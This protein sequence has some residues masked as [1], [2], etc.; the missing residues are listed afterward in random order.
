M[1]LPQLVLAFA[2]TFGANGFLIERQLGAAEA[3]PA[4]RLIEVAED[5]RVVFHARN[6]WAMA[7][8]LPAMEDRS[9]AAIASGGP[10]RQVVAPSSRLYLYA[11]YYLA[12]GG[13][14]P[15]S[16]MPVDVA[17]YYFHALLGAALDRRRSGDSSYSAWTAERAA[18]LMADVPEEQ[19]LD[20]YAAALSDFG[21]H[22]LS[23][24]NEISRA[25][26]R[27]AARGRDVCRLLES[28][29]S[30][31]GLWRRSLEGG[32]Y[33]GSYQVVEGS[34]GPR[35]ARSRQALAGSDKRRFLAEVLGVTWSGD[36][37]ADFA[38]LCSSSRP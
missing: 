17:E 26:Q 27:Q 8:Y 18:E 30:L 24:H 7:F 34:G 11:P 29:A 4:S 21:A 36:P 15:L 16:R 33:F 23:V 9:P 32:S 28:P 31:F 14:L 37:A 2:W 1:L 22:L 20:V 3:L 12:P 5:T 25:A 35:A 10:P 38:G 6:D 13:L 19:R